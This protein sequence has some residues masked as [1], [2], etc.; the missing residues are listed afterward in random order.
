MLGGG[1]QRSSGNYSGGNQNYGNQN[2]SNQGGYGGVITTIKTKSSQQKYNNTK[3][4][5]PRW[6]SR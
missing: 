2:Y 4:T 1:S 5:K 3:Q 6:I